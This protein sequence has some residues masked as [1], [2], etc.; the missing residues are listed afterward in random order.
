MSCRAGVRTLANKPFLGTLLLSVALAS[1]LAAGPASAD[2]ADDARGFFA[3]G[4]DLRLHGDCAGAIVL[5][6]VA[7]NAYPAALGSLRNIAECGETLG[8]Y[9]LARATWIEL[10]EALATSA[11][12]EYD[13]WA[14]DA[15]NATARL[16]QKVTALAV[17]LTVVN[18]SGP[19]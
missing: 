12:T 7:H 8:Q 19:P 13:G 17:D 6:R 18:V 5:F 14:Q 4:R 9:A 2:P 11:T 15:D 3:R 16:A 10:R 1:T